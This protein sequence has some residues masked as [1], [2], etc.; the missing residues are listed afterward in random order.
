M[1]FQI[2]PLSTGRL[3]TLRPASLG[4][5]GVRE[6]HTVCVLAKE[7]WGSH[8]LMLMS[9]YYVQQDKSE[10][11]SHGPHHRA[12]LIHP[13]C[14]SRRSSSPHRTVPAATGTCS[15]L[16]RAILR[17]KHDIYLDPPSPL[18]SDHSHLL[19]S[20]KSHPFLCLTFSL[21]LQQQCAPQR[22]SIFYNIACLSVIISLNFSD[23]FSEQNA[24]HDACFQSLCSF[25]LP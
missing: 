16:P 6:L 23:I 12:W 17:W 14:I 24:L 18:C 9:H 22:L 3:H 11:S 10:S 5:C 21:I 20:N 2:D 4:F 7:I 19:C 25:F 1:M 8:H 13:L 15:S